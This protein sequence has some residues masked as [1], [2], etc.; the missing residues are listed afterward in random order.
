MM[1]FLSK[2]GQLFKNK[3]IKARFSFLTAKYFVLMPYPPIVLYFPF[4]D[5]L[6]HPLCNP[7]SR[8]QYNT[9]YVCHGITNME[10]LEEKT[11]TTLHGDVN[12]LF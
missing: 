7:L 8:N 4:C 3:I 6:H 12:S 11:Y 5:F 1:Y 10:K 2:L 9:F